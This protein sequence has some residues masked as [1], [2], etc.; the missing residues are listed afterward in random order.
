MKVITQTAALQEALTVAGSIIAPR[1]PKPVLLCVKL[2]AS[3]KT[4]TLLATDLEAGCRYTVTAVQIE[5]EGE[6]LI[7]AAQLTGIVRE[8]V[9]E[10]S[11]TLETEKET[12]HVHGSGSHFKIFG[13]DPGEF[14]PVAESDGEAD[15]Q[16]SAG[17]LSTMIS[18]TL[19]ATAKAHSHYAI[20]GVLWEATGKKLQLVATDGHRLAQARGSLEGP[21]SRDVSAIV[22][23]KLMALIGRVCVNADELLQVKVEESQII[24]RSAHAVLVSSLVQGN[25]PKYGDVIP[26]ECSRK[27]TINTTQF[28][29]RIRQAALL[30][31]E[32]SRGVRLSFDRDQVRLSSR[33]PDAGEADVTCQAAYDGEAMDI[34]FNPVFLLDALR[35]A[36]TEEVAFEMEAS[37]KPAMMKAGPDFLYVLM[38]VDIG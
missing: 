17:E 9:G 1:T 31:D 3:D 32:E 15:F 24:V 38:P 33:A 23:G 30:T 16:V 26:K 4:L 29:H 28:E 34:A 2:V 25:F 21:A 18:R 10:E 37:N 6:A 13:Y 12:C 8:S 22:P 5:E 36:D 20:S 7:P 14:P 19:F 11:L 27:A 35:V